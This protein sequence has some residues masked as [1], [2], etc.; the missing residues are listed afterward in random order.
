MKLPFTIPKIKLSKIEI[1]LLI[2]FVVYILF[3][4]STPVS[5]AEMVSNPMS[6]LIMFLITVYLFLYVSP[7]L[8]V[9][10]I[11]VVYE[12]IRRSSAVSISAY[13]PIVNYTP[14]ALNSNQRDQTIKAMNKP[15]VATLEEE[16]VQ[17][18]APIGVSE[19]S[20]Y[21]EAGFKPV[22]ENVHNAFSI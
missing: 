14:T 7:I 16:M 19:S 21:V 9:L 8:G 1:F 5:M 3:P 12:L 15:V 17:T 11:F 20:N 2:I 13:N 10:Y 4:I 18:H 22:S 6:L